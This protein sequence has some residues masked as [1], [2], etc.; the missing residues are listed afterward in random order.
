MYYDSD[1]DDA[2]DDD[3]DDGANDDD[4]EEENND[5]MQLHC[6]NFIDILFTIDTRS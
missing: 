5:F 2:Y 3:D 4:D 1:H 6:Y